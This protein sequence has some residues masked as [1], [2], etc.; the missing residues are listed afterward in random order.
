MKRMI[1][2]VVALFVLV[3]CSGCTDLEWIGSSSEPVDDSI[4]LSGVIESPSPVGGTIMPDS[5]VTEMKAVWITQFE[6]SPIRSADESTFRASFAAM[7]KNCA[8]FGL[9]T[10][11]VQV[12]PNGDSFFPSEYY[13][14]SAYVSGAA[15]QALSYDPLGVMV[16]EAHRVGIQ[17]HA[18]IN[19]YRLQTVNQMEL[20]SNEFLTRQWYDE[21]ESSDR[22]VVLDGTCY[23]NPGHPEARELIA[24]GVREIAKTY[25]IDGIHIDDYFYPTTDTSFDEL[26]FSL[27]GNGKTLED[28]R[29][30]NVDETVR[31]IYQ[32]LKEIRPSAVFSV[33][34]SGNM[35]N[36][37]NKLYADT[38]KWT[39]E[40]GYLDYIIPQIYWN[41][42]HATQPFLETLQ[43]WESTVKAEHVKLVP[44]LAAYKID[45]ENW[46][47]SGDVLSRM[48]ADSRNQAHYGGF[49]LYS[50]SAMF[51]SGSEAMQNERAS[52]QKVM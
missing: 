19:P 32:S 40:S 52:L 29:T 6:I 16:E 47:G 22:V 34:P 50:Y 25:E 28:F 1:A 42:D 13:P 17:I 41:Y 30:N 46:S 31:L 5:D 2:L 35:S 45:Q 43:L 44:G 4:A 24:N 51:T 18:W 26:A 3:V 10:V 12:R 21:R 11:F 9:N 33:S 48:V 38:E 7:M 36:N 23:L 14:W 49:A 39:S 20:I 15:G 8:D 37:R 27:C